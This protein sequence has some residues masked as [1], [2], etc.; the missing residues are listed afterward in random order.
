MSGTTVHPH[1]IEVVGYFGPRG[2]RTHAKIGGLYLVN[3]S[4]YTLGKEDFLGLT[5]RLKVT[6]DEIHMKVGNNPIVIKANV[7]PR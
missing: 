6:G 3:E 7:T 5:R 4:T 2:H 1:G